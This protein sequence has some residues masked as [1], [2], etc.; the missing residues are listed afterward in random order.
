MNTRLI[1]ERRVVLDG[2][3]KISEQPSLIIAD[4]LN[5]LAHP[6]YTGESAATIQRMAP[7]VEAY[8]RRVLITP[9]AGRLRTVVN[10]IGVILRSRLLRNKTPFACTCNRVRLSEG[11]CRSCF[12]AELEAL[13]LARPEMEKAIEIA[14]LIGNASKQEQ[15][16]LQA[17]SRRVP[18]VLRRAV[19]EAL[20]IW[21][22]EV[23]SINVL[24][25]G[26]ETQSKGFRR[27]TLK[28]SMVPVPAKG[29]TL[30][31]RLM[32]ENDKLPRRSVAPWVHV[33]GADP[34]LVF[35]FD[36]GVFCGDS[37]LQVTILNWD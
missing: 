10:R 5:V 4:L 29:L 27:E 34:Y 1:D 33:M 23:L 26:A 30:L 6:V 14:P 16:H 15:A 22:Y 19:E 11:V 32:A 18:V 28:I 13:R 7:H 20:K 24:I 8:L 31:A 25:W 9:S 3:H 12:L 36:V 17:Y 35:P 37:A 21:I 2:D